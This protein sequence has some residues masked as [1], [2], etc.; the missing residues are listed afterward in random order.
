MNSFLRK[1]IFFLFFFQVVISLG[2]QEKVNRIKTLKAQIDQATTDS[3]KLELRLKLADELYHFDRSI[4]KEIILDVKNTIEEKQ[5]ISMYFKKLLAEAKYSLSSIEI[6][7]RNYVEALK[8]VNES[9]EYATLIGYDNIVGKSYA[10]IGSIYKLQKKL[11]K[12]KQ[13]YNKA[14]KMHRLNGFVEGEAFTLRALGG[15]YSMR[16]KY[17]SARYHYKRAFDIDTSK[18]NRRSVI[19]NIATTYI[20]EKRFDEGIQIYR[21]ELTKIDTTNYYLLSHIYSLLATTYYR[22]K[23]YQKVGALADSAI[24]YAKKLK[25]FTTIRDA[26]N[27]KAIASYALKDYR[28]SFKSFIYRGHYKDS[29]I[30]ESEAKRFSELEFAYQYKKEREIAA[31]Q[32]KNEKSKKTLYFILLF[33][34]LLSAVVLIYFIR[35]NSKQRLKLA[36]NELELKEVEKLKS[37]LALANRENELKKMVIENSITEEMLNKTLDDIKEIIT[38]Q[39]ESKR[40]V[41]LKT[42]SANLLSEKA[43]Q[44]STASIKGYIDQVHMDFKIFID[45]HYPQLTPKDRELI[46]LM[47][48]GLSSKQISKILNTTLPAIRSNRYR[49]RKKLGLESSVDI[50]GFLDESFIVK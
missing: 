32:L 4:S 46:Y 19:T 48:A 21:D 2:A 13:Y 10:S 5:Y 30:N 22:K 50:V 14:I 26:Y 47:K 7:N 17:D 23:E 41:A 25:R 40:K 34:S 37:D 20:K 39:N 3:L 6:D 49:L 38:F 33:I 16:K 1:R 11:D 28:E 42:L 45:T 12:A 8:L 43:S 36:K 27:I 24:Y 31:I 15:I 29:V 18:S 35:K 44:T 9:L